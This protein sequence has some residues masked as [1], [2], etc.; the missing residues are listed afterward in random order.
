MRYC[1]LFV[2][3][4]PVLSIRTPNRLHDV[5][6][7]RMEHQIQIS[8]SFVTTSTTN[9]DHDALVVV[10]VEMLGVAPYCQR[11]HRLVLCSVYQVAASNEL[12]SSL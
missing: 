11:T 2:R 5:E 1:I 8:D 12:S 4:H 9:N 6:R 3:P 7:E 10:V